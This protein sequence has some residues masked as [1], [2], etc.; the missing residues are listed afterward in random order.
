M[1][2]NEAQRSVRTTMEDNV[3]NPVAEHERE[4]GWALLANTAGVGTTLAMLL[5]GG[6]S[7][8]VVGVQWTIAMAAVAAVFGAVIGV[9]V[10]RVSQSTGMSSTVTARFH[11]LGH[12][13]SALASLIFGWMILSFLA[14]ENVLLYNGILFVLGMA[15]SLVN[16]IVI[17]G[18]LT[19]LWFV[20]AMFG[21]KLVMKT[22][23]WLTILTFI[24]MI[25]MTGIAI[26]KAG[27]P[28]GQVLALAPATVT[29]T[30]VMGVLAGMCG[31]A[32]ALSLA[33]ADFA[34]YARTK[35]DADIMAIGG[36]VIVLFIVISLGALLYQAGDAVVTQYLQD[37][38]NKVIADAQAGATIVEKVQSLAHTNAG[39]YFVMLAGMI[40]FLVM[41]AAQVKAQVINAYS[42]SLSLT[43][44]VDALFH[45]K[46]SRILMLVLANVIAIAAVMGGILGMFVQFLGALGVAT[47]S[48]CALI[49]ADYFI[50]RNQQDAAL[51]KVERF[52]WA[53]II[54]MVVGFVVSYGLMITGV[55]PLGFLVTLVL[56]PVLYIALRRSVLKEGTATDMVPGTVALHEIE[57]LE[58]A[59]A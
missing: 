35:R 23:L 10:A 15:P 8:Y 5:V 6:G 17:Y 28:A 44:L 52:N 32:G 34:R 11:G 30:A 1:S 24:L 39:A 7:S 25:V 19:A 41:M 12:T 38:A 3:L 57:S 29:P 18:L 22:S 20:L 51:H 58:E 43:N 9:L 47:F 14:L 16:A 36:S 37:P 50:L 55:T 45:T 40:G 56:T 59:D 53:G 33:G 4:S 49:V 13:G 26:T 31:M 2:D 21:L 42:G 54:A 48:L 27:M 46:T